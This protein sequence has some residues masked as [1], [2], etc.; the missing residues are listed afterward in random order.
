M[1]VVG[2]LKRIGPHWKVF[3]LATVLLVISSIVE[4][5]IPL[6]VKHTIDNYILPKYGKERLTGKYADI[7]KVPKWEVPK[8]FLPERYY[9]TPE[10]YMT[11]KEIFSL[12]KEKIYELRSGDIKMIRLMFAVFITMLLLRFITS[13]G[14]MYL[15]NKVSQSISHELRMETFKHALR[16][17]ASY[18][19]KTP[20]GVVLTRLTNDISAISMAYTEGFLVMFKDVFLFIL[21]LIVMFNISVKLTLLILILIPLVLLF[22]YMFSK[23]IAKAWSKVRTII[24]NLNAF[25]QESIWGLKLIQNLGIYREMGGR[26]ERLNRELYEAYMRVVYIFGIFMPLISLLSYIGIAIIIWYSAG[27]I[28]RNEITFG[29]LVAFLSYIDTLFQ[30]IREFGQRIQTLQSAVAGYE[31][32]SRF[33]EVK[34]EKFSGE[35]APNDY[36]EVIVFEDVSFSYDGQRFAVRN[37]SFKVHRGEKIALVGRTGSGKST[38]LNLMMGFFLP[39]YGDVKVMGLS[40]KVWDKRFLRELYAPVMQELMVFSDSMESNLTLG[41]EKEYINV[42]EDI[43]IG[44]LLKKKYNELSMGEKQL[45]A[46]ARALI[47]NRPIIIFDEATSNLDSLTELKIQRIL[48]EKFSDKTLIIVA[49]RLA[50]AMLADRIIVLKDGRIVEVGTHEE[51]LE[52]RGAYYN[53]YKL[54]VGTI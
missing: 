11:P 9:K 4:I 30:P 41:Y 49:H 54:Q 48:K 45:I 42:L 50:T 39:T 32:V 23:I 20:L 10:G 52:R 40:T 5:V 34:E 36:N 14:Y 13:Y 27:G 7:T 1:F 51:L 15:G 53:L 17:P 24:A 37:I 46:I 35:K 19:N 28:L 44:H 38:I 16:L 25:L 29:S 12:P 21:A 43:G 26:F 18:F 22:S 6:L 31:K 33:M 8:R 47:F 3:S 2:L